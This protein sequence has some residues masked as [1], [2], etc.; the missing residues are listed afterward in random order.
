MVVI[1]VRQKQL[2][3]RT[4]PVLP[5]PIS[6]RLGF[7]AQAAV[8]LV[9]GA[10]L[11]AV[12]GTLLEHWPWE[13]TALPARAIGAWLLGLGVCAAHVVGENDLERVQPACVSAAL[14]G[15]LQLVAL[16]RYAADVDWAQLQAWLYVAFL[17]TLLATGGGG[18]WMRRRQAR[19][20]RPC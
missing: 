1:L 8:L 14:L 2:R 15:G 12:P 9:I 3:T 17:I 10:A 7:G 6:L 13:L 18:I 19:N 5:L 4:V 20:A 11:F 16:L